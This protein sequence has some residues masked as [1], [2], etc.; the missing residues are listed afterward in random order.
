[1]SYRRKG[2][3]C[4]SYIKNKITYFLD[5]KFLKACHPVG[6]PSSNETANVT[7]LWYGFLYKAEL[8]KQSMWIIEKLQ[9]NSEEHLTRNAIGL[10]Y[11]NVGVKISSFKLTTLPL[12]CKLDQ[13]HIKQ[14]EWVQ[15]SYKSVI[16]VPPSPT[17]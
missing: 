14:K 12:G 7:V 3:S 1:M 13:E 10:A 6:I 4:C 8:H 2:S 15:I 5:H 9:W 17:T 11:F 16:I